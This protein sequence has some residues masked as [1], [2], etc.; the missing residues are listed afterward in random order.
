MVVRKIVYIFVEAV[1]QNTAKNNRD[2]VKLLHWI[3]PIVFQQINSIFAC[4]NAPSRN[5]HIVI[6]ICIKL[7][8]FEINSELFQGKSCAITILIYNIN[9]CSIINKKT[10]SYRATINESPLLI[11]KYIIKCTHAVFCGS[12]IS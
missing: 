9:E 10:L 6:I 12:I 3:Q 2:N 8:L 7:I 5:R 1:I 11:I 4:P